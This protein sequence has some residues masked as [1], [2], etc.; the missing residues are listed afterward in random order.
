[1]KAPG[2]FVEAMRGRANAG[3]AWTYLKWGVADLLLA[4]WGLHIIIAPGDDAGPLNG[5]LL[6]GAML[7]GAAVGAF[8][9]LRGIKKKRSQSGHPLEMELAA[10]GDRARVAED[11]DADFASESFTARRIQ[12][13]RR[14]LCYAGKGQVTIRRLDQL[15]WVYTERIRHRYN[16]IP[17][18][19]PS[20]QLLAWDRGGNGAA[21]PLRK[22]AMAPVLASVKQHAPWI[23]TGYNENLKES[24]NADRREFIAL[25]D[26]RRRE[27][28]GIRH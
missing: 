14:W 23:F 4:A 12:I 20:Y 11:I 5:L 18:R 25:L 7:I 22:H 13:G 27:A 8:F 15:A 17:Y 1:M 28:L 9:I 24:W 26:A 16:M 6:G 3:M 19:P 2:K 21:I 10:Y